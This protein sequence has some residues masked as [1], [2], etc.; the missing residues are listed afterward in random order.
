[1]L[2]HR[3]RESKF[4]Y[5]EREPI[6]NALTLKRPKRRLVTQLKKLGYCV[7]PTPLSGPATEGWFWFLR[8]WQGRVGDHS[9]YAD[10]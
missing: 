9:P 2:A 8:V 6:V 1:M 10:Y 4:R 5:V 7:Q 3:G